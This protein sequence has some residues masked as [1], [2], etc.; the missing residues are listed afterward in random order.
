[1]LERSASVRT[2]LAPPGATP[3]FDP[4]PRRLADFATIGEALDYAAKGRRGLNFH[5]TRGALALA[6]S[7]AELRTD[8]LAVGGRIVVMSYQSLEDR[9][10]KQELTPRAKSRSPEGL[11]VELPGTG[12]ELRILTRVY[13]P[14]AD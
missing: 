5:D 14:L 6:Y 3:T 11:P 13:L 10:V 4:L 1:M 12:P 9:V 7:F 2:E 8:A